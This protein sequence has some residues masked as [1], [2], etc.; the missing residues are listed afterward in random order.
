MGDIAGLGRE[1]GDDDQQQRTPDEE[2]PMEK[3]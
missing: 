1:F 2:R 3:I